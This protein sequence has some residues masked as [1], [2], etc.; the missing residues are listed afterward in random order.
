ME[1]A[2]TPSTLLGYLLVAQRFGLT[3]FQ[4]DP[5]AWFD[6]LDWIL[7][8]YAGAQ[9]E[10]L[11]LYS[12]MEERPLTVHELRQGIIDKY[13][14][15]DILS[16]ALEGVEPRQNPENLPWQPDPQY[17]QWLD[18]VSQLL[19]EAVGMRRDELPADYMWGDT[20]EAGF[21]PA[22]AIN[23]LV[24]PLDDP[25]ALREAIYIEGAGLGSF[26]RRHKL[27]NQEL[28]DIAL[29][30]LRRHAEDEDSDEEFS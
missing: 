7:F 22:G 20:Y 24:G 13:P 19:V 16:D 17:Q 11:D 1:Q 25:E 21:S 26:Q 5:G 15:S 14:D 2:G 28:A 18:A 27:S 4:I 10:E 30:A 9:I 23:L 29:E 6:A 12:S 8:N 3:V